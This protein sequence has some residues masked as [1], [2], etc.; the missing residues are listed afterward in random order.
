MASSPSVRNLLSM[1]YSDDDTVVWG[2]A[3]RYVQPEADLAAKAVIVEQFEEG[4]GTVKGVMVFLG[5]DHMVHP[6]FRIA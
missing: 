1:A 5:R 4:I 6:K 3:G 2:L